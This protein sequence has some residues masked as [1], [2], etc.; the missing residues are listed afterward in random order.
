VTV[1]LRELAKERLAALEK[2]KQEI[3]AALAKLDG[4][5]VLD[6]DAPA[7]PAAPLYKAKQR[8]EG[9]TRK[10][11]V[12]QFVNDEPGL[13]AGDIAIGLNIQPNYAYRL[14]AELVDEGALV[15][16][17]KKYSLPDRHS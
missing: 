1:V 4:S 11:Q 9:G 12:V 17:G 14:L 2:E 16:R 8:R 10:Q 15:K 7:E 13:R 5:V 3:H 6:D